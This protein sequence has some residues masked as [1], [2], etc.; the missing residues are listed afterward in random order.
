MV[1]SIMRG[2]RWF[3]VGLAAV[4]FACT[5]VAAEHVPSCY[6][7]FYLGTPEHTH[8]TLYLIVDQTTPLTT[9]MKSKVMD[10]VS[11][12]GSNG[13]RVKIVR[14]SANVRGEYTELMFDEYG[15]APPTQEYLYH[16]KPEDK[17]KLLGCLKSREGGFQQRFKNAVTQTLFLINPALP[18][19]DLLYSLHDMVGKIWAEDRGTEQTLLFVSDGLEN[20][21][22]ATFY[23]KKTVIKPLE[24]K[25]L[26][27]DAAKQGLIPD[28]NGAKVYMYGLGFVPSK[29]IYV[30]P[31]LLEPL[32]DFWTQYFAQGKAQLVQLGTPEL[33][34]SSVKNQ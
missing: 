16:V 34:V 23:Q 9:T 17:D 22:F 33:L 18:K 15:D 31:K 8:R 5:A 26:I 29:K 3:T 13:E 19:S 10:L 25:K 20:S 11:D 21:E 28:F 2:V 1:V 4:V 12:W 6:A 27:D 7:N 14:F 32:R 24:S 30:S